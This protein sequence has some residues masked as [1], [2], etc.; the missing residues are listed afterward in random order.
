MA[1]LSLAGCGAAEPEAAPIA[2]EL[3]VVDPRFIS[4][5][6]LLTHF[7]SL[8]TILPP[9]LPAIA[10]LYYPETEMERSWVLWLK[11][12]AAYYGLDKAMYEKFGEP[13][14]RDPDQPLPKAST[15]ARL[16]V[17]GVQRAEGNYED[18]LGSPR[19]LHLIKVGSRWWISGKSLDDGMKV[20]DPEVFARAMGTMSSD[21]TWVPGFV[22]RVRSGEFQSAKEARDARWEML[23]AKTNRSRSKKTGEISR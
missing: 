11:N 1:M 15:P 17:L 5:E 22:S 7:N 16:T 8:N 12:E 19:Q 21:K 20:K 3:P 9:D 10:S 14:M 6:A 2:V 18:R 23:K 4:A 13:F